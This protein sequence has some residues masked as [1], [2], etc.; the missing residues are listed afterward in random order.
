MSGLA[1]LAGG[2][3]LAC[4][5]GFYLRWRTVRSPRAVLGGI[6]ALMAVLLALGLALTLLPS[7]SNA[8][9]TSPA[10]AASGLGFLGASLAT[11]LACLGA[12]IAVAVVGAAALGVVGEKPSM[13]GTT[14][15][16]LGLA[17]GIAIY[18][19]IVSLLILGKL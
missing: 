7:P 14:L 11:G 2:T 8:A 9:E 15:I 3:A 19:V 12:G 4:I 17:E 6:L 5:T 16:Y 18:G 13:L 10:S 1:L